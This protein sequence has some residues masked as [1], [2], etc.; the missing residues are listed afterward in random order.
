[1]R[2]WQAGA[3]APNRTEHRHRC[4]SDTQ[5]IH[6]ASVRRSD[7]EKKTFVNGALKRR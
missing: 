5:A 7:A 4:V 6:L 1:M 3:Q 2:A